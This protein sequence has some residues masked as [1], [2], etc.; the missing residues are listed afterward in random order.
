MRQPTARRM[1]ANGKAKVDLRLD[2]TPTPDES[3]YVIQLV[4]ERPEYITA[5]DWFRVSTEG[6]IAVLDSSTG[7]FIP[8]KPENP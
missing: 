4:E 7:E 1:L 8:I 5:I 2:S 3:Y 6:A